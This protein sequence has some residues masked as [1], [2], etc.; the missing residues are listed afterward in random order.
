[1]LS[2]PFSRSAGSKSCKEV[3][4]RKKKDLSGI[5]CEETGKND[6]CG[7]TISWVPQN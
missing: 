3:Y 1:M 2:F 4:S 7:Y 6:L 5:Q